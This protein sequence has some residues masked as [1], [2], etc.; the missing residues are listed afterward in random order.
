[1]EK[2]KLDALLVTGPGQ[3]NPAMVYLTG[4]GH[5][6][7]ADL[8]VKRGA[9]PLLFFRPMERDE[10]ARTGLQTKSLEAYD[11]QALLKE[12]KN[13]SIQ[14]T[15]RRYQLMLADAGVTSGKVALAGQMDAGTSLAV[16]SALQSLMPEIKLAGEKGN[17]LLLD[18]MMTKDE[19]EIERIRRMGKITVEVVGRIAEFLG[20]QNAKDN[21]L[22]M[23]DGSP[24]TIGMV[25][26][27]INLWLAE[28]GAENPEGTIFAQ[29]YDSAIPH[30]TGTDANP[31][32]LGETIVFDI[33]PCEAGGGYFYDFT[34]TWCL[35]H[36]PDD[37]LA[38]YEQVYEA[39]HLV[40]DS[41]QVEVPFKQY[42]LQVC[43]FFEGCGHPSILSDPHTPEGYVHSVGHGLGLHV[44]ERPWSG[45]TANDGDILAPGTVVTV[46]PGLYY[47]DR[48]IGVRLENTVWMRPD[49]V[50]EVLVE[51]PMDLL[52]PLKG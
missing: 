45:A 18:A 23:A 28:L 11:Y 35:G 36:V 50:P 33:F 2:H 8:I 21:L 41:L 12:C 29:G 10:A 51:Y 5:L 44:H 7:H 19:D 22:V 48:K 49:G 47:P 32:R 43:E 27:R 25:K 42:Q 20:A 16:F 30:S 1:M 3:H 26:K 39:Y 38:I 34:R 15:A 31:L 24:V 40:V 9:D 17:V 6:T 52:I 46:E 14:A 4:G 13:N 37:V